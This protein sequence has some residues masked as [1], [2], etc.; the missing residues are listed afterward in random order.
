MLGRPSTGCT[1][2][3]RR[4]PAFFV[5]DDAAVINVGAPGSPVSGPQFGGN[6]S[7]GGVWYEGDDFPAEYKNT[8]FHGDYGSQWIRNFSF[9][10]NNNPVSVRN[11]ASNGCVVVAIATHP[12][13]GGLYY[14]DYPNSLRK[15][16]YVGGGNH[17][18]T[19]VASSDVTY[20]PGPLTVHFTGSSSSDPEGL[21][22]T[23]RWT[24][25]MGRRSVRRPTRSMSS[26]HFREF[27]PDTT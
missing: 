26:A 11:F 24:S 27:P 4:A 1:A 14:V 13:S 2:T 19:A 12:T 9:D 23:Y 22:L 21:P 16:S 7:V 6:C 18:P 10:S 20:G 17:P 5:G 3:G 25:A 15:V 8:Y